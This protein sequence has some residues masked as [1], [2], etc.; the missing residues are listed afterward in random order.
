M[1]TIAEHVAEHARRD[2][3]APALVWQDAPIGYG[4]LHEMLSQADAEL[5]AARPP[6]RP[7]RG[8]PREEVAGGDR[9]D[10]R[11]PEGAPLLPPAVG[12]AG[13]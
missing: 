6:A 13:A 2:P 7:S 1:Q 9:A 11:L 8:H 4:E 10:P 5:D 12:R 3:Q